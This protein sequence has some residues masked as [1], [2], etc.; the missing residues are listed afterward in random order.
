MFDRF[1]FYRVDLNN[2]GYCDW[3]VNMTASI[4][5]GGDRTS[6][7]TL[8]LGGPRGWQRIGA[9]IPAGKPDE[10]GFGRSVRDQPKYLFGEDIIV[11]HDS[12]DKVNYL[13]TAFYKRHES[14]Q[15]RPGYHIYTRSPDFRSLKEVD[16]WQPGSKGEAVYEYFKACGAYEP[17]SK[18]DKDRAEARFDPDIE[19]L[20]IKEACNPD[21]AWRMSPNRYGAVSPTLLSRCTDNKPTPLS[22]QAAS[23]A[24]SNDGHCE[25]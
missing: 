4:S 13:I 8:Y 10:L 23:A 6:L 11:V 24:R 18:S 3:Y 25:R 7:N 14:E 5:T 21:S 9:S 19:A 17:G 15:E 22:A 1:H 20:E 16:K 12:D 2:D